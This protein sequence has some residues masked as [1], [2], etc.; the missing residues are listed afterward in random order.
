VRLLEGN[1]SVSERQARPALSPASAEAIQRALASLRR[2]TNAQYVSLAASDGAVIADAGSARG[3]R[4]ESVLAILAE[5]ISI[6]AR[7]NRSWGKGSVLSLHHYEGRQYELY[8]AAAADL[9]YLLLAL[10]WQRSPAYSGV[11]WLFVR[12]TMQ[13][14]RGLLR[15]ETALMEP[16]GP[17]DGAEL[18]VDVGDLG[19][20][21]PAQ[22]QALGL[23]A[24]DAVEEG[25]KGEEN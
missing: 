17:K 10:T 19:G 2:D 22:A 23:L 15:V 11:I 16:G 21:T 25:F 12:R 24:E 4:L 9:P 14:L 6:A 18:G 13:E 5:E 3:L 1:G 20:L 8:A 7:L